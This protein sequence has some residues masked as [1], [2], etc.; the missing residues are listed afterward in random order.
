MDAKWVYT[1]LKRHTL[2]WNGTNVI[3]PISIPIHTSLEIVIN[4]ILQGIFN[5]PN[6]TQK[7][8]YYEDN[9]YYNCLPSIFS[10]SFPG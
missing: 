4:I 7:F 5:Y 1:Y 3:Q 8:I 6:N 10:E 2:I 9:N